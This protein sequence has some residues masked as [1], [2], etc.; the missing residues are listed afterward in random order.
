[1]YY[2]SLFIIEGKQHSSTAVCV[3]SYPG[4]EPEVE[5]KYCSYLP[6]PA[7]AR[8]DTLTKAC[9]LHCHLEW[10]VLSRSACSARCGAGQQSIE[11]ACTRVMASTR[12][13]DMTL[14]DW[15]CVE[16]APEI[17]PRPPGQIDCEGPC[18]GV[19]WKYEQWSEVSSFLLQC[20]TY[21][22]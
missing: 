11:Y 21:A 6:L 16:Q 7:E 12:E 4:Y 9:N 8:P 10:R 22:L 15:Y 13:P 19:K 2:L 18:E 5:E 3:Q 17:G 1:M 20:K 14:P